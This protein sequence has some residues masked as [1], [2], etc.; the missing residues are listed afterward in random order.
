MKK[1]LLTMDTETYIYQPFGQVIFDLAFGLHDKQGNMIDCLN[2]LVRETMTISDAKCAHY[3]AKH[4]THYI[5][6]LDAQEIRLMPW[7]DIVDELHYIITENNVDAICAYNLPFDLTALRNTEL[8]VNGDISEKMQ[9]I[10]NWKKLCIWNFS[11]KTIA[12]SRKYKNASAIYNW[13]T[14]TGNV[15]TNAECVYKFVSGNPDFV[16]SH[17]AKEDVAIEAQIL[18]HCYNRKTKVPYNELNSQCWKHAQ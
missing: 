13:T 5:P 10:L 6:A 14:R 18:A 8:A 2:Y 7:N 1:P 15:L 12:K 11:C 4:Y 3:Q 17:T 16:E 9:D